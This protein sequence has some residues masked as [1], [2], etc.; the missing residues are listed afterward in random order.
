MPGES[1]VRGYNAREWGYEA[2]SEL[3]SFRLG[4]MEL[5]KLSWHAVILTSFLIYNSTK[6]FSTHPYEVE[7]IGP[8]QHSA[9]KEDDSIAISAGRTKH[10]RSV[11]IQREH[12]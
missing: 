12:E 5:R 7:R 3:L 6:K 1:L 8:D 11:G 4:R 2:V 10:Y 9:D